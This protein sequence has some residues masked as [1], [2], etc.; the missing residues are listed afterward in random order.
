[1]KEVWA[2]AVAATVM[3]VA[4]SLRYGG[5]GVQDGV[6]PVTSENTTSSQDAKQG[7]LSAVGLAR[8]NTAAPMQT[9]EW[10]ICFAADLF[11]ADVIMYQAAGIN[12]RAPAAIPDTLAA[13]SN[14][15]VVYFYCDF[16]VDD[17]SIFI[18]PASMFVMLPTQYEGSRESTTDQTRQI[19]EFVPDRQEH[20]HTPAGYTPSLDRNDSFNALE[21]VNVLWSA[22]RFSS[23]DSYVDTM[24]DICPVDVE[25][26]DFAGMNNNAGAARINTWALEKRNGMT[27]RILTQGDVKR[28]AV[29]AITNSIYFEAVRVTSFPEANTYEGDF[30][31]STSESVSTD[32]GY[33]SMAVLPRIFGM[34]PDRRDVI[35]DRPGFDVGYLSGRHTLTQRLLT[36]RCE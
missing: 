24:R 9:T 18:S 35:Q 31:K 23:C 36:G 7:I 29:L 14:D 2:A 8:A 28:L 13:T 15:F 1:M 21:M 19:F 32:Y 17:S 16:S 30:W 22:I 3:S 26:V 27:T 6:D 25:L 10:A 4:T 11:M 20:Y 5:T 33:R 34:D 12:Q